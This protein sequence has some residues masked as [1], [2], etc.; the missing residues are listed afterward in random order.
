MQKSDV[1]LQLIV[2]FW[3]MFGHLCGFVWVIMSSLGGVVVVVKLAAVIMSSRN[4]SLINRRLFVTFSR[5]HSLCC[6]WIMESDVLRLSRCTDCN[7]FGQILASPKVWTDAYTV[8][9]LEISRLLRVLDIYFSVTSFLWFKC[10]FTK[11][12]IHPSI[13]NLLN[14]KKHLLHLQNKTVLWEDIKACFLK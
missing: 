10:S 1:D 11:L 13:N 9:G 3:R 8:A 12:S 2:V 5:E 4:I 6:L 7:V 14:V